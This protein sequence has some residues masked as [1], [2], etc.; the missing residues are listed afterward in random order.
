MFMAGTNGFPGLLRCFGN[1]KRGDAGRFEL[2]GLPGEGRRIIS[3]DITHQPAA[4]SRA[5]PKILSAPL[6]ASCD[7]LAAS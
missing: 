1:G 5:R 6:T 7:A 3:Q 4:Q 2:L